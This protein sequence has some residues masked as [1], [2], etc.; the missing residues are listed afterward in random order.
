MSKPRLLRITTVPISLH[1]LIHGQPLFMKKNGLD[2]FLASS[3]GPE[4]SRIEE[5][6][7]TYVV[8][9]P[10]TREITPFKDLWALLITYKNIKKINPQIVHTHTPKAGIIGMLASYLARVPN[11]FHT[12][13][14]L[15]LMEAKGLKKELLKRIE[16]VTYACA[17]NIYP[18]SYGLKKY[19]CQNGLCASKKL[20]VIGNGS[21]NGIDVTYYKRKEEIIQKGDQARKQYNISDDVIVFCY[22]GRLVGDKGINELLKAYDTI[23]KNN[24]SCVLLLVG[25]REEKLDPLKDE[26]KSYIAKDQ[27]IKEVGYVD[28]VR[29]YM[30]IADI[31]VFPSYREGFPNVVLQAGAMELPCIVTDINGNNEI[32]I[33]GKNGIIVPPKDIEQLSKA[34]LELM[35]NPSKRKRLSSQARKHIV[36]RYQQIYVWN[37]LLKEYKSA[38]LKN[39]I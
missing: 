21:S 24:S 37:E 7:N 17:T 5:E 6:N 28:D 27:S 9:L 32:I 3:D 19:I 15:P 1:K 34:M 10:L 36:E 18:N 30:A 33:D 35:E 38:I 22:V 4:I 12:V 14:G 20:K 23:K 25:P 26:T 39:T 2:I 13:A 11:R 29:P 16:K 8:K 31:F